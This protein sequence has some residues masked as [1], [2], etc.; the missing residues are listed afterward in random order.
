V[1]RL[2]DPQNGFL[3]N[4]YEQLGTQ[5]KNIA[6]ELDAIRKTRLYTGGAAAG[7]GGF[8]VGSAAYR[9]TFGNEKASV[10]MPQPSSRGQTKKVTMPEASPAKP[11][12][13]PE[14]VQ[15]TNKQALVDGALIGGGLGAVTAPKGHLFENI[16]R[17]AGRGVGTEAGAAIGGTV[18]AAGGAL[19]GL[20]PGL[21]LS[22]LL[23]RNMV[24]PLAGL[25][26]IAGT[27]YG[28]YHGGLAGYDAAGKL[29]GPASY[30]QAFMGVG[31]LAGMATAPSK[32]EEDL[33]I[34]RGALRG[35]GTALGAGAGAGLGAIGG[36]GIGSIGGGL[37]GVLAGALSKR[38]NGETLGQAMGGGLAGGAMAGGGL[39]YLAGIPAGAIYGGIKGNKATKALLDKTAPISEKKKKNKEDDKEV[40]EAAAVVLAQ[41]QR[42]HNK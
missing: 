28:A 36:A 23:K 9:N 10:E 6:A 19:A 12:C 26:G 38:R 7:V 16:G 4:I 29:M 35:V 18:G 25:G 11:D 22:L 30:K 21:L 32:E 2:N 37:L 3:S 27:G 33:S 1:R 24:S 31:G 40:K 42:N 41:L 17:G 34:G 20:V 5:N 15:M 13:D 8:G 39:G 14:G